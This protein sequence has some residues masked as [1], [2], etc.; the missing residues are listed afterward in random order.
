[1][2]RHRGLTRARCT[3]LTS[4]SPHP[5]RWVSTPG[6]FTS[7]RLHPRRGMR[8]RRPLS[9]SLLSDRRNTASRSQSRDP[10]RTLRSRR[11]TC[12]WARSGPPPMV[13]AWRQSTSPQARMRSRLGKR[14]TRPRLRAWRSPA[15]PTSP[16]LVDVAGPKECS[17]QIATWRRREARRRR[18][19]RRETAAV[20]QRGRNFVRRLA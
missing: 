1:M 17:E 7:G 13:P 19:N 15:A 5:P 16:V 14:G 3:G 4:I 20:R 6:P 12:A 10:T 11:S 18:P 9:S 2:G 8:G